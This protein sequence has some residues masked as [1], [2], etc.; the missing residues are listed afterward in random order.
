MEDVRREVLGKCHAGDR[1]VY[2]YLNFEKGA[3][4]M[5]LRVRSEGGGLIRA[6]LDH[7]FHG[8]FGTVDVPAGQDW[9]ELSC[10]L[11]ENVKGVHALWLCFDGKAETGDL[12]QVDWIKFE[13]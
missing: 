12:F 8:T 4:K 10:E 2:K 5:T 3:K 13:N 11:K 9:V 1:V 7:H 6:V